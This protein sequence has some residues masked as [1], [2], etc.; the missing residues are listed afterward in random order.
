MS[1]A[2]TRRPAA[3]SDCS[4]GMK[5]SLLPVKSGT[6]NAGLRSHTPLAGRA[7]RAANA[8]RWLA[9]AAGRTWLGRSRYL[10]VL[11]EWQRTHRNLASISP[12][13]EIRL[14]A[15]R[16]PALAQ[17]RPA[18][19][20]AHYPDRI[21]G[22]LRADD[23]RVSAQLPGRPTASGAEHMSEPRASR[24]EREPHERAEGAPGR[25]GRSALDGRTRRAR[26]GGLARRA[27]G[28]APGPAPPAGGGLVPAFDGLVRR[29]A[30][31]LRRGRLAPQFAPAVADGHARPGPVSN[32]LAALA[33]LAGPGRVAPGAG[34]GPAARGV[35][36]LAAR[37]PDVLEILGLQAEPAPHRG[38][39]RPGRARR[40]P[41]RAVQVL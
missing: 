5:S 9:I 41:Q 35:R 21:R 16:A 11:T 23:A 14:G 10:G 26:R 17:H 15:S 19:S 39:Q 20:F 29:G 36:T 37:L 8:P 7:S 18:W 32:P 27:A 33:G 25:A 12:L 38:R 13:L 30:P 31:G 22:T 1:I 28:P 2:T 4:S 6:S 40:Y 34:A 3:A 24:G